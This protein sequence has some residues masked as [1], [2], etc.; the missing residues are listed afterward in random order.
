MSIV[1]PIES[2]E[3]MADSLLE[4]QTA[5]LAE[6]RLPPSYLQH[7]QFW[8]D[9][10]AGA[11]ALHQK[12]AGRS[13]LVAVNGCQGSGKTTLCDY[14]RAVLEAE[15]GV[16]VVSLSLDDFYLTREERQ[17]LAAE[18]HPLLAT[19]GVP[20]THDLG[21]LNRTLDGLLAP[22]GSAPVDVP[23][24]DKAVDDRRPPG[25]WETVIPPVQL[26]LLE[27][28]C[29]GARPQPAAQLAEAVNELERGEDPDG[30]W[31]AYVNEALQRE[32][33]PLYQRVD[34]WVMLKAPSFACVHRWRLEQEQKLAATV[35]DSGPGSGNDGLM[36]DAA[37][38]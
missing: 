14:L 21:L 8:F 1:K 22:P 33:L 25:S 23:R 26:V 9:S 35:A 5:F 18:V 13:V 11:L 16:Q 31:R 34:Q 30:R 12:G 2:G 15:Y 37:L 6:H 4:W 27:G 32:F 29:M 28:W 10:L 19:R 24:F 20:G 3:F 17:R 7:A 38:V 36:N